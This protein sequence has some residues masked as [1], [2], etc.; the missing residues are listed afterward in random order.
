MIPKIVYGAVP[1]Y[2]LVFRNVAKK[3]EKNVK[4]NPYKIRTKNGKKT[5]KVLKS[6]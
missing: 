4:N 6:F 1:D 5:Q 3:V 2:L